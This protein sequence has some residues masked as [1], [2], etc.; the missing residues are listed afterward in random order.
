MTLFLSNIC[1]SNRPLV[2]AQKYSTLFSEVMCGSASQVRR[3][4]NH[5]RWR[6]KANSC[7]TKNSGWT[8]DDC[9]CVFLGMWC[10]QTF[11]WVLRI[12][13]NR[14]TQI[15]QM[16]EQHLTSQAPE[17]RETFW[18]LFVLCT[19]LT[20]SKTHV[21]EH[22]PFSIY[23]LLFLEKKR[24]RATGIFWSQH[25]TFVTCWQMSLVGPLGW[26]MLVFNS[27]SCQLS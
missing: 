19:H 23:V 15:T 4:R 12:D 10:E 24:C 1:V 9:V 25:T 7:V 17:E 14:E 26:V 27:S 3:R 22:G 16:I 6:P 20:F 8:G 13:R 11:S 5:E 2:G 21:F 18:I